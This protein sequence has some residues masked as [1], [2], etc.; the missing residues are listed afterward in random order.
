MLIVENLAIAYDSRIAVQGVDLVVASGETLGLIGESGSGKSTLVLGALR[1]LPD[2]G[3][4]VG[5]KVLLDGEPLLDLS[6]PDLRRK[7]WR[8][9]AYVPQ[10]AMNAFDPVRTLRAQFE[11]TA[12]AHG[13][14]SN[15]AARARALFEQ[16]GLH[17]DWLDRFPHQFSGGMKQRATIALALL[18][19]P[20]LLIADEPTTGLDVIVQAEIVALLRRLCA[21]RGLALLLVS[22]DLGVVASLCRRIAVMYAGG[23]VEEGSA[24]QVLGHPRHPYTMALRL[25]YSDV[26]GSAK[27]MISIG[28]TP[29]ALGTAFRGCAFAPRCPF[30][31][32]RCRDE[33]PKLTGEPTQR[34]ACHRAEEA[35]TLRGKATEAGAWDRP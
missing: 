16:V 12:R 20:R 10:G 35:E 19:D 2:N 15:I 11:I 22:H 31:I 28:G 26:G 29:P 13:E 17:P 6:G 7:R 25:A 4:I 3:H 33:V 24:D 23:I 27:T 32:A 1:L 5:G 21:D 14:K 34:V 9:F 8:S 18:F 30:A